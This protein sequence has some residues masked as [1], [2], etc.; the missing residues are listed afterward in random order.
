MPK[1]LFEPF[2]RKSVK[3]LMN[4]AMT[5]S[6][7]MF[8]LQGTPHLSLGIVQALFISRKENV[9]TRALDVITEIIRNPKHA[10]RKADDRPVKAQKHRYERRK[11]KE[12]I[13][14]GD[15]VEQTMA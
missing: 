11:V 2:S 9:M 14:L 8:E 12:Y 3:K 15:W 1:K 7:A 6:E 5:K 13:R 10:F 4:A